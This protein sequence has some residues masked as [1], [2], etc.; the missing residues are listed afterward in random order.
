[1]SGRTLDDEGKKAVHSLLL[2][3]RLALV[4]GLVLIVII[5]LRLSVYLVLGEEVDVFGLI[6]HAPHIRP[7]TFLLPPLEVE[8]R[9]FSI[10]P[11]FAF[12]GDG[13]N[14]QKV[15]IGHKQNKTNI[16]ANSLK[17]LF[18]PCFG[19]LGFKDPVFI[20]SL[21]FM[22]SRSL[23]GMSSRWSGLAFL[24]LASRLSFLTLK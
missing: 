5:Q 9:Y 18:S 22:I 4:S 17:K 12:M 3:L 24:D 7:L 10:L 2:L 14:R 19:F 6:L 23:K 20:L 15:L 8:D 11:W 21:L 1:M 16:H 13:L